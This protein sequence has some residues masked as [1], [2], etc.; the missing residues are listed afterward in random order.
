M[1]LE[2]KDVD[3]EASHVTTYNTTRDYLAAAARA[4]FEITIA[5]HVAVVPRLQL[6]V[7]PSLLDDSG[8]A[9]RAFVGRPE[10]AVRW[11]F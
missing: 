8:F 3:T 11:R 6:L 5:H 1:A 2:T 7:F 9:P 10:I 4:E